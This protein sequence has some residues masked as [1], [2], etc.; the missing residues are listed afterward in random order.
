MLNSIVLAAAFRASNWSPS[1]A[2][3]MI[4]ANIIAIAISKYSIQ[5]PNVG[6]EIPGLGLS[7]PAF[8]AAACF[9]HILGAG[10]ILGLT[11]TGAL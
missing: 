11:N 4:I 6:P 9:G 3:V 5:R 1:V 10:A 8:I 7:V 2:V